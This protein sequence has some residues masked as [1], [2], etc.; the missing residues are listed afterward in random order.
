[1]R[2]GYRGMIWGGDRSH[3]EGVWGYDMEWRQES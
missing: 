1:M 3:E 2:K